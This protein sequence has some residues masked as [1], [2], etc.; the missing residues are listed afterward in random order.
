MHL[1][2]SLIKP[3]DCN[4]GMLMLMWV[5]NDIVVEVD[6][7]DNWFVRDSKGWKWALWIL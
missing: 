6:T 5:D 4:L 7:L 3:F 1:Y 2:Y